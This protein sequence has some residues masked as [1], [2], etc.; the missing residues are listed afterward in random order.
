MDYIKILLYNINY[1]AGTIFFVVLIYSDHLKCKPLLT[2]F[3]FS[4]SISLQNIIPTFLG[5]RILPGFAYQ[6]QGV[7]WNSSRPNHKSRCLLKVVRPNHKWNENQSGSPIT[8]A[9][10]HVVW[11]SVSWNSQSTNLQEKKKKK[12]YKTSLHDTLTKVRIVCFFSWEI[13][14]G[15]AFSGWCDLQ[16]IMIL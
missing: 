1:F 6:L 4:P 12:K 9:C 10:V 7:Y 3:C 13:K 5:P 2:M 16:E 8:E 11:A 14:R 15:H